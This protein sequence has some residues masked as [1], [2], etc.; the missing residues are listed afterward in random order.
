ML[1]HATD[2]VLRVLFCGKKDKVIKLY[3]VRRS[4]GDGGVFADDYN[5]THK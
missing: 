1:A 2:G 3:M 4:L 5:Y